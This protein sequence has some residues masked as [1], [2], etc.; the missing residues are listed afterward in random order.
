[1]IP[2]HDKVQNLCTPNPKTLN[3]STL[4]LLNPKTQ[5]QNPKPESLLPIRSISKHDREFISCAHCSDYDARQKLFRK[6]VAAAVFE[7]VRPEFFES[8]YALE[9]SSEDA[10]I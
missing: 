8:E 5:A 10:A 6:E 3:P 9:A 1:M 4:K 2:Y 7:F